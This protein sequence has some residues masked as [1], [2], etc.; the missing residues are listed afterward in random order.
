MY[1]ATVATAKKKYS[2]EEKNATY[3]YASRHGSSS[4]FAYQSTTTI[5]TTVYILQYIKRLWKRLRAAKP[6]LLAYVCAYYYM[7]IS[8]YYYICV[9]HTT[10]YVSSYYYICVLSQQVLA[11]ERGPL[12]VVTTYSSK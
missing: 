1:R 7:R 6:R 12:S 4:C 2:E 5:Y 8:E 10:T 3:Q 11:W 9:S